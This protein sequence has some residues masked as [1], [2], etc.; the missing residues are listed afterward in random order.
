MT[1]TWLKYDGLEQGWR[2]GESNGERAIGVSGQHESA[3]KAFNFYRYGSRPA[4]LCK[5]FPVI[6][7]RS[8]GGALSLL[9]SRAKRGF[10][11]LE[12]GHRKRQE[13][14]RNT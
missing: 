6:L 9:C 1:F 2:C 3:L 4:K 10:Y 14:Q 12:R 5:T 13:T 11:K 8:G 7:Y